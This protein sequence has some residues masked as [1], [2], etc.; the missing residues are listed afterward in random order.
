[1]PDIEKFDPQTEAS[2]ITNLA[3]KALG[4]SVDD[5]DADRKLIQ[6]LRSLSPAELSKTYDLLKRNN[7]SSPKFE[8]NFNPRS[9]ELDAIKFSKK[10][11]KDGSLKWGG[12]AFT[13]LGNVEGGRGEVKPGVHSIL[14]G[15]AAAYFNFDMS[16]ED[17]SFAKANADYERKVQEA[18]KNLSEANLK[19]IN[20][21]AEK[22]AERLQKGTFD[23][24]DGR[25][26]LEDAFEEALRLDGQTGAGLRRMIQGINKSLLEK[27]WTGK[28]RLELMS[29]NT[30]VWS[31]KL[32]KDGVA[33]DNMGYIPG[34]KRIAK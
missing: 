10:D 12:L 1:M 11:E 4:S 29:P 27:D 18:D 22:C 13:P 3:E 8:L 30:I 14:D 21:L 2:K 5:H 32:F 19:R 28:T 26:A 15:T 20:E 17:K 9:G 25:I 7:G 34:A 23:G 6:E 16:R 31:L 24:V 33:T